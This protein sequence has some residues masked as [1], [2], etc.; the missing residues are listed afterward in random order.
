MLLQKKTQDESLYEKILMD[1]F[2]KVYEGEILPNQQLPPERKEAEVLGVSRG[3]IRK[4]R[5][6]LQEEG[7]IANTQGRGA[8]YTPL[9]KRGE[10]TLEIVA[11][12]VPVHNPFFMSYYR[13]F[14]KEAEKSG[15]LVMIKQLDQENASQL[16]SVLF[17]L[18]QK[19]I[20]DIVF[21]PY[22]IELDYQY[23][24]RLSG[25]GMNFIFFDT[26][27]EF[28]FSD[29]ISL[30]NR[31]AVK[32]LYN[33]LKGKGIQQVT[34]VGWD[35]GLLTSNTEREVSFLEIK[36][37]QDNLIRLPWKQE[38][39]SEDLMEVVFPLDAMLAKNNTGFL[40]GNGHIGILLKKHLNKKGY[41]GIT[42]CTIDNFPESEDLGI[43][44]YEQPFHE[45]GVLSFQR[46][47]KRYDQPG[48]WN[49]RTF[50][51]KGRLKIR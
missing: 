11:V 44:V 51:L 20:R 18:F 12:V 13:A 1:F 7:Y 42:V 32:S 26:V 46:L 10:G 30:D 21:W 48:E 31:E 34:Y 25:L 6:L 16:K 22:D 33:Y 40:C 45:M 3:T 2:Q 29:Y 39:I 50:Y 41:Y 35:S 23:I 36:S 5:Q 15:V 49:S 27:R 4:V 14:E 38:E 9:R 43:T 37:P 24:S 17:S 28:S 19:G 8:V 47:K